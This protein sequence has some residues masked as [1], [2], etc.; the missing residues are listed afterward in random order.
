MLSALI[1]STFF[2]AG[3]FAGYM[4]R[5]WRSHKRRARYLMYGPYR[6][7]PQP[8]QQKKPYE[9]KPRASAF[10]HARRAF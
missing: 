6:G 2:L 4:A 1:L 3:F 7:R 8:Q 9:A 5:T 10:G